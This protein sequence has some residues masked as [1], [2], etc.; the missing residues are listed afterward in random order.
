MWERTHRYRVPERHSL[1]ILGV[2]KRELIAATAM[3]NS[4]SVR[5][6]F[7]EFCLPRGNAENTGRKR[8]SKFGEYPVGGVADS[9]ESRAHQPG[10]LI[11]GLPEKSLPNKNWAAVALESHVPEFRAPQPMKQ[12][13][14]PLLS[15]V[16]SGTMTVQAQAQA[17][18]ETNLSLADR[19]AYQYA[20]ED[21]YWR[22]RLWP[23]PLSPH[24]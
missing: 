8:T 19:V 17:T 4:V 12:F 21:V 24:R 23:S 2:A 1:T 7:I 5:S 18:Q 15:L 20:I 14:L 11:P 22:H 3:R 9:A 13:L 6:V 10:V 16:V